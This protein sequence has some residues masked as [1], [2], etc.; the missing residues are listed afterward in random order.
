MRYALLVAP[1]A[2]RVYAGEA[3]RLTEAE[4]AAFGETVLGARP[5]DL[6]PPVLA[7]AR[8]G[9]MRQRRLAVLDPLCGR[10]TTL[11]QALRCGYDAVGIE[12]DAGHVEA[13]SAFLR[14]YLRHQRLKHTVE[15]EAALIHGAV[16]RDWV[17]TGW[18]AQGDTEPRERGPA[19]ALQYAVGS[20]IPVRPFSTCACLAT[21]GR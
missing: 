10:G 12:S 15:L 14:T 11:N 18:E 13:Y 9:Q 21:P 19:P 3:P 20:C 6:D 8:A 17:R 7:S 1:S 2:N 4:L 16:E 5:R